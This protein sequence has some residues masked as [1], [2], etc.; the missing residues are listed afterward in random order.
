MELIIVRHALPERT[1][2]ESATADPPLTELGSRQAEATA[3]FLA[4]ETI[5]HIVASPLRRA[6][7]TAEPLARKLGLEIER[8]EGL[9]EVDAFGDA[10]VPAE[11]LTVDHPVV[12]RFLDD[13][14]ALFAPYGGFDAYRSQVV[15]AFDGIVARNRGRTVAVFCHATVIGCYLTALVGHADPFE[16]SPDYCAIYR[17]RA[18]SNNLRT[19]RSANET[20]HVRDLNA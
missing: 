20:G 3:E 6:I 2:G 10:Y 19:L 8:S 16:L 12:R 11:Q 1:D 4:G 13:P 9:R 18:S 7:E 14:F 17:V 15:D 5:D